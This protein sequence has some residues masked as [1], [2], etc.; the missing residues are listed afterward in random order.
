MAAIETSVEV[1]GSSQAELAFERGR[2]YANKFNHG[3]RDEDFER[4]LAALQETLDLDPNFS[5]AAAEIAGLYMFSLEAGHDPQTAVPQIVSWARRALS[6][7]PE[8][9]RALTTLT[10]METAQGEEGPL[11]LQRGLNAV[12]YA[13]RFPVA[14][15]VL[16][17]G[18]QS[19]RLRLEAAR[20]LT[21]LDP[22][23]LNGRMLTAIS[24]AEVG[25]VDEALAENERALDLEPE[26]SFSLI[27]KIDLLHKSG[28]LPEAEAILQRIEPM[29]ADGRLNPAWFTTQRAVN[30]LLRS[31]TAEAEA[32]WERLRQVA[33]G[34]DRFLYWHIMAKQIVDTLRIHQRMD[35]ARELLWLLDEAGV[36]F[37]YDRIMLV[38]EN[39]WIRNDPELDDVVAKS[40]EQFQEIVVILNEARSRGELPG[41]LEQPLNELVTELDMR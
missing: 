5:D 9:G 24:L 26:S 14:H 8:N 32:E 38:P 22:L 1:A 28:R 23:Y 40:R 4:S 16:M 12:L 18:L 27:A 19:T 41:Y 39:D 3:H 10:I 15:A 21:R 36:F 11:F 35:E 37:A 29:V 20:H 33:S 25:R 17:A 2:Y 7:E 13:P 31:D 30:V 6:I 34:A